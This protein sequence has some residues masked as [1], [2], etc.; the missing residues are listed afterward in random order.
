MQDFDP[1]SNISS[2]VVIGE[3]VYEINIFPSY[4]E[5]FDG[6]NNESSRKYLNLG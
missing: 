6:E 4:F 1:S 3:F 5:L 2:K